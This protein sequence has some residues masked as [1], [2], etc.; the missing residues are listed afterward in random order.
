[1][2][3]GLKK[4]ICTGLSFAMVLGLTACGGSESTDGGKSG[5][6]SKDN[7]NAALAKEYVY[8]EQPLDIPEL[9]SEMG[10]RQ[11]TKRG[12]T[13]YLIYEIYNW[14]EESQ[15]NDIKLMSINMDGSDIQIKDIQMFMGGE[16]PEGNESDSD[17]SGQENAEEEAAGKVK[18]E[19]EIAAATIDAGFAVDDKPVS[20]RYEYTGLGTMA[21]SSDEKLYG[22]RDY[23]LEDYTDEQNPITVNESYLCCWD[24]EGTMLWE[25]K[26]EPLQ[27]EESYSYVSEII[28]MPEGEIALLI[29]GDKMEMMSVTADGEF[30][31]RTALPETAEELQSISD[32]FVKEDGVIVYT[33]WDQTDYTMWVNTYDFTTNTSGEAQKMPDELMTN[34]YM[35]MTDGG[36][37]ADI[38]YATGTGVFAIN[39]GEEEPTQLMSFINSDLAGSL[40]NL[41]ILDETHIMGFYHDYIDSSLKGSIFTKVNPEDVKD[42]AVLVLAANY[43]P[44]D[45]R[46]RVVEFNRES[47]DYRIVV[48]DYSTYNTMDDYMAG[49]TQ[50]NNDILS[51]GMPDI[52]VADNNMPMGS[53]ISKGLV[54]DIDKLIAEDEELSQKEFMDN[55]F[56]AYRVDGKL[57]YVIPSFYVM[58]WIGKSSIVGDRTTWTMQDMMELAESL[59]EGT[60][61]LSE[62]TRTGFLYTMMQYCGSD[63]IDVSSGKCDFNSENFITMLEFANTLPEELD[64]GLYEDEDYWMNYESQYREDRTI[65]MNCYISQ[66]ANMKSYINGYFGEDISY[67]G[68]PNDSGSGAV[69]TANYQYAI[70]AK[71]ENQEGAWEFLRYYLTDEYQSQMEYELPVDKKIF[72]EKA[73][74]AKENS[75]YID[76]QTGE[77]VEYEE[78]FYMNG[79]SFPLPN[80]T[81]EQVDEYISFVESVNRC[82]Y[83]NENIQNIVMEEAA[84]FFEGQ[85]S[86]KEVA[87]II[88]SRAQ[89]YV[90]EN[91]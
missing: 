33:F 55:V 24:M 31:E 71:S 79:E 20:Y 58:T 9:T 91:M 28:T 12:D 42:K 86:A 67:I 80:L 74:E 61:M 81:Q 16:A 43:L 60:Q 35:C 29:S 83:Y 25:S 49:Y 23:Y 56:E 45:L 6:N 63:F 14:E 37:V 44:W 65:L 84:P 5:K 89:V 78:E 72:V 17:A 90:N 30:G 19:E 40:Y 46:N 18:T 75:Y 68:F 3:S 77:K 76:A 8:S 73:N 87:G 57:Y 2:K 85:K 1:M 38:I 47:Q 70:S 88:Q 4:L 52:L 64:G 34:G 15:Q 62:M 48:K 22:I 32:V 27:T 82:S 59:P 21:I 13:V 69:V 26:M 54:A 36:D 39:I 41:V 10:I 50:L 51:S 11:M 7:P 66:S 53:Y